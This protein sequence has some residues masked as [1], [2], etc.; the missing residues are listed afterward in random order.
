MTVKEKS[1]SVHR[2]RI[3]SLEL[4]IWRNEGENRAQLYE[5]VEVA[6]RSAHLSGFVLADSQHVE[7]ETTACENGLPCSNRR[8]AYDMATPVGQGASPVC[9]VT[10][11]DQRRAKI[12]RLHETLA[13]IIQRVPTKE[14]S[15]HV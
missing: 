4:A 15:V 3:G 11:P 7:M 10:L 9:K 12:L 8:R 2:I 6:M 13:R 1:K 5:I 14:T